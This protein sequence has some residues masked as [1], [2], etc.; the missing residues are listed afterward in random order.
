MHHCSLILTLT[1]RPT[2][3]RFQ[4]VVKAIT[5]QSACQPLS[6]ERLDILHVGRDA[7]EQIPTRGATGTDA[8][9]RKAKMLDPKGLRTG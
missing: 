7:G 1:G 6:C 9:A 8:G 5:V 3:V 2:G 4:F